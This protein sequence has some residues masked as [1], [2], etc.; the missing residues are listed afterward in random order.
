MSSYSQ[1]P[2][3]SGISAQQILRGFGVAMMAISIIKSLGELA[4]REGGANE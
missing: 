1:K 3:E 4:K 2:R